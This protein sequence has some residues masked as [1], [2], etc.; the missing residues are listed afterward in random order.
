MVPSSARRLLRV[1]TSPKRK[2]LAFGK[3]GTYKRVEDLIAAFMRL[4]QTGDYDDLE[5]VIAGTDSPTTPGYLASVQAALDP[6]HG[7]HFTGYVA[8]EDVPQ[9]FRDAHVVVFPYSGTTGSSGPL[10]QAGSYSRPVVA[11]R[12]GDLLDLIDE[13]GYAAQSYEPGDP[14]S[15]AHAIMALLDNPDLMRS[16]GAQNHAAAIGLSLADV[17]EWHIEHLANAAA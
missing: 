2:L 5:L 14:V 13:E 7:V 8:E 10:H 9:L 15:L 3:F 11:P 1:L 17:T 16:M 6:S 12:I 4:R